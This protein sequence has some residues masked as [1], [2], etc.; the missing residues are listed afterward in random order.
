V[1]T[2][3]KVHPEAWRNV[4]GW[5]DEKSLPLFRE[6][7]KTAPESARFI[8]IGSYKGQSVTAVAGLLSEA[9]RFDVRIDCVDT[10][11]GSEDQTA[12]ERA[13]LRQAF[14]KNVK[15]NGTDEWIGQV[16][17]LESLRAAGLYDSESAWVV[18]IDAG[19]NFA[20]VQSDID[21]WWRVVQPNGFMFGDDYSP[22]RADGVCAAVT[23]RFAFCHQVVGR[24][25]AVRKSEMAMTMFPSDA[26]H[27][28][29]RGGRLVKVVG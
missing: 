26:R 21:A 10:F 17:A 9:E 15:A 12:A 25:W 20:D 2:V 27:F 29:Y 23:T 3:R 13:G 4:E 16:H 8:E 18:Y 24:T 19:H 28:Q 14:D 22:G 6:A 5:F 11:K 1:G 7:I